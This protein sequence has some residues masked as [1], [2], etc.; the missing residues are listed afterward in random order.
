[1]TRY[2]SLLNA[3]EFTKFVVL[4]RDLAPYL[5]FRVDPQSHNRRQDRNPPIG[6]KN[7]ELILRGCPEVVP[8]CS[9]HCE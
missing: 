2:E 8:L 6:R 1:M 4:M 7:P 9:D 5:L 3:Q